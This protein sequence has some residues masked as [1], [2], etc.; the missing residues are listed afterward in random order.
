[1]ELKAQ[2][3]V[4]YVEDDHPVHGRVRG[5]CKKVEEEAPSVAQVEATCTQRQSEGSGAGERAAL[6]VR[7]DRPVAEVRVFE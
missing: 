4:E 6:E 2:Q 5:L 7:C 3:V 1:M